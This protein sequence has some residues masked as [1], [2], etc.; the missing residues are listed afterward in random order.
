MARLRLASLGMRIQLPRVAVANGTSTLRPREALDTRA[1]QN[2]LH[3]ISDD[4]QAT[5]GMNSTRALHLAGRSS[6]AYWLFLVGTAVSLLVTNPIEA[7]AKTLGDLLSEMG[8]TPVTMQRGGN[9]WF[10]DVKL[11]GRTRRALVDTGATWCAVDK[12]IAGKLPRANSSETGSAQTTNWEQV[13][14]GKLELGDTLFTNI[15]AAVME[16]RAPWEGRVPTGTHMALRSSHEMLLGKNF[17]ERSHAILQVGMRT[18]YLRATPPVS[19]QTN[20]LAKTLVASGMTLAPLQDFGPNCW[21]VG[22]KV[23]GHSMTMLLDTGAFA[24]AVD[25][26]SAKRWGVTGQHT[27]TSTFGVDNRR[28]NVMVSKVASLEVCGSRL[29]NYPIGV[30][31]LS[32]WGLGR[33]GGP[34]E[35]IEGMIAND[36]LA[37]ANAIFDCY[38]GHLWVVPKTIS[39]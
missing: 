24:T 9:H 30:S 21:A 36:V 34:D 18:L 38:S 20:L 32:H 22:A 13:V 28:G 27:G 8:Y 17:L 33:N 39:E 37:R 12:G 11:N 4:Y 3:R 15:T 23:N 19:S 7:P 31:D 25:S 26:A 29:E 6:P 35:Q 2:T 5:C 16:L 1:R 10:V 14:I